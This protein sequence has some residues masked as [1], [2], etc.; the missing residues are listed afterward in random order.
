MRSNRVLVALL[1]VALVLT[2]LGWYRSMHDDSSSRPLNCHFEDGALVLNYTYG[3]NEL[4]TTALDI[5]G[6]RAVISLRTEE[7]DGGSL[8]IAYLGEARYSS[9][10]PGTPVTYPDG[11]VVDCPIRSSA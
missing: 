3:S 2:N 6:G 7:G 8:S 10:E 11:Q 9:I 4:V 5:R 1:A